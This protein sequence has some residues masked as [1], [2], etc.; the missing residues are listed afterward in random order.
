LFAE[1]AP[2]AR[3]KRFLSLFWA[4]ARQSGRIRFIREIDGMLPRVFR[5]A[6]GEFRNVQV[7]PLAM[8]NVDCEGRVSTF[9]PELLGLKH[10]GYADFIIG[11]INTDSLDDMLRG[12][13]MLAMQRDIA[14]GVALCR[15]TCEYFSVCGGGAPVNKLSENGSFGST[16]TSFCRVTHMVPVD[17][18]LD[19]FDRLKRSVDEQNVVSATGE[20]N[21]VTV[22]GPRG[23]SAC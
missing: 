21:R 18:I 3:F 2:E 14:A 23:V 16:A 13:A 22:S 20:S 9:S 4:L 11:N 10:A 1:A 8:L 15:K 17:I 7:E 6:E 19:A 12:P 5:S